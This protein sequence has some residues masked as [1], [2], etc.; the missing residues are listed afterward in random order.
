MQTNSAAY[1]KAPHTAADQ[2]TNQRTLETI[3]SSFLHYGTLVSAT[4]IFLGL[5]LAM[6]RGGDTGYPVGVYPIKPADIWQG[7]LAGHAAAVESLGFL[8]LLAIPITRV[9]I[10]VWGYSRQREYPIAV[11]SFAVLMVLLMSFLLGVNAS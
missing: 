3:V 7:L 2:L 4:L 11:V 9:A 5:A 6:L 10:T 8:A 1:R